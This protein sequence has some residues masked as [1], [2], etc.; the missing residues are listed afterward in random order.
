[1]LSK[2]RILHTGASVW[3]A[4]RIPRVRHSELVTTQHADVAIIGTGIS[5][6]MIAE[7]LSAAGL[8]IIVLDRRIPMRGS[9]LASTALLQYA[10]DVPLV[11]LTKKIGIDHAT[12]A[13]RRSKLA[14]ESLAHKIRALDID[15][16]FERCDSLY[17][18]GEMLDSNGLKEEQKARNLIGIQTNYLTQEDLKT[19]YGLS[20]SAALHNYDDISV[21]PVQ[22]T[23]GFLNAAIARGTKIYSPIDVTDITLKK[24]RVQL[25]TSVGC[26]VTAKFVVF[27]TGYEL[28]KQV[29][30]PGHKLNSTWAFSTKPQTNHL[31]K[32]IPFI[33]EASDPYLYIKTTIDGRVIC[34]GED[35]SFADEISRDKLTSI[36][37]AT[38]QKK[39]KEMYPQ[40]DCNSDFSWAGTFGSS[41]TGLPSI[42]HIPKMKNCLGAF[43]YGGNGITFSRIA[44]EIISAIITGKKDPDEDVFSF[45]P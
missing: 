39:L 17:L 42:G 25:K 21:N 35:E 20:R 23:A 13:W 24:E 10:I 36:K 33:C 14:L 7:E 1:M 28:P 34:G 16:G 3:N 18:A 43:A 44:A 38:L 4:Y 31:F 19:A 40:L 11:E 2:K 30:F 8:S 29:H 41:A 6:A 26:E 32:S 27:A 12:H 5:G 22:L 9:T 15:C 37:I 45:K